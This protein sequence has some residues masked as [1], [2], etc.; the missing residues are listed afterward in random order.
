M[1]GSHFKSA[2]V[3][4]ISN[5]SLGLIFSDLR[6][7]QWDTGVNYFSF[8]IGTAVERHVL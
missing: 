6:L 4:C 8:R 3:R 1:L 2:T 5:L 7:E